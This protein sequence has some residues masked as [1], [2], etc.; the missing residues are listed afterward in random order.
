MLQAMVRLVSKG[1]ILRVTIAL[2]ACLGVWG[3]MEA[4][5]TSTHGRLLWPLVF[6]GIFVGITYV[7]IHGLAIRA[8]KLLKGRCPH[9]L[10]HGTVH[11]SEHVP[12]GYLLCPTCK[13]KWPEVQGIH[14]RATG[15]EH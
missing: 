9:P 15:R 2:A 10:C 11:H 6:A 4:F 1:D 7:T 13:N 8:G 12:K 5:I 14:Y 3:I